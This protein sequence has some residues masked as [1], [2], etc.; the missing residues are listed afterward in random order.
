MGF[1]WWPGRAAFRGVSVVNTHLLV[2]IVIEDKVSAFNMWAL[3]LVTLIVSLHDKSCRL[4][5]SPRVHAA[6]CLGPWFTS[7]ISLYRGRAG[8]TLNTPLTNLVT[9]GSVLNEV[10]PRRIT[11]EDRALL[12]LLYLTPVAKSSARKFQFGV[13]RMNFAW[14]VWKC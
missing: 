6:K 4:K 10:F 13:Q 1:E 11:M 3:W 7:H 14:T 5:S 9:S 2:D 8:R 12:I